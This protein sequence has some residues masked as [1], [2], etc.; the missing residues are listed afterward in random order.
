MKPLNKYLLILPFLFHAQAHAASFDCRKAGTL[1]EKAICADNTLSRLD[2]TLGRLYAKARNKSTDD[3]YR[4]LT[5]QQTAWL[6]FRRGSCEQAGV[7]CLKEYYSKRNQQLEKYLA[8]KTTAIE[9][10]RKTYK[11]QR[12]TQDEYKSQVEIILPVFKNINKKRALRMYRSLGMAAPPL[13]VKKI[14]EE[15]GADT[16]LDTKYFYVALNQDGIIQFTFLTE[17]SGAYPS[18][19]LEHK[20]LDAR[21]G[22]RIY[23]A[24]IF[25][26]SSYPALFKLIQKKMQ[27]AQQ[28]SL[29]EHA[30]ENEALQML[31]QGKTV[32]AAD[33]D[34][35]VISPKGIGFFY[36][37]GFPHAVQALTPEEYY[38]FSFAELAPYMKADNILKA[39]LAK[40]G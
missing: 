25:K 22:E 35:F 7:A 17:G 20:A 19:H 27:L 15:L 16:W 26:K 3:E 21:S 23:A 30:D 36:D 2:S 4:Q 11:L 14:K 24:D 9:I 34:R 38:F 33:L 29:K 1:H 37:Y 32:K 39:L 8:G 13:E 6:K 12:T 10:Q 18:A 31:L 5:E 28:Q 40:A